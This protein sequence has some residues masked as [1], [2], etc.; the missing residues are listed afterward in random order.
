MRSWARWT[1]KTALVAAGFAAAGGGLSGIAWAGTASG[2]PGAVTVL[3]GNGLLG[4][5]SLPVAACGNAGALLGIAAAGCQGGALASADV[6][7]GTTG[8]GTGGSVSVGSGNQ[9]T[10][11]VSVPV[12]VCGN[13]AAVLGASSAG[14]AGGTSTAITSGG[15]AGGPAGH[16]PRT[17]LQSAATTE[18][19]QS[20]LRGVAPMSGLTPLSGLTSPSGV[21]GSS[22][23]TAIGP[24]GQTFSDTLNAPGPGASTTALP[25]ASQLVGLGA[26]P[27]LADLPSLAGLGDL[28]VRSG[29]TGGSV[30]MPSSALSAADSSGMSSNSFA[31]LAIGALL[32]GAAALKIA[33]RRARDRKAGIGAT[34]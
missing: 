27:G 11:P 32:A 9:V 33:S 14:C 15:A 34:I 24:E 31:V 16:R 8:D 30:L 7:Q 13:A 22:G 19:A 4:P 12:S 3:G 2:S 1:A 26:L 28:P 25:S 29:V 21:A 10:V 20:A 5:V 6:S 17:V 18:T 23:Q